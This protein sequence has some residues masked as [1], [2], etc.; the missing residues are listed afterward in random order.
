MDGELDPDSQLLSEDIIKKLYDSLVSSKTRQVTLNQIGPCLQTINQAPT[1][2]I[3]QKIYSDYTPDELEGTGPE[4]ITLDLD[5]F[6]E[7]IQT[8]SQSRDERW[9]QLNKAFLF[10]DKTESGVIDIEPMRTML[11][12]I[13]ECFTEKEANE[14]Y[15]L[16]EPGKNGKWPYDDFV[17]T[18]VDSYP[19]P[20]TK[21]KKGGSGKKKKKSAKKK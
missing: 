1:Q 6:T 11:L 7:I 3:L 10:F 19:H 15:K 12:T 21:K 18:L 14:F 2:A 8:Y 4:N 16:A 20:L 17:K 13:G 5:Q 9:S